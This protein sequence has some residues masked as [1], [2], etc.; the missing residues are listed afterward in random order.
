[1]T[2]YIMEF[3]SEEEMMDYAAT[4]NMEKSYAF[5]NSYGYVGSI[6]KRPQRKTVTRTF[7]SKNTVV[8]T[9]VNGKRMYLGVKNTTFELANAKRMTKTTATTTA[10]SMTAN[11]FYNWEIAFC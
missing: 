6:K 8:F 11:G 4:H 3:V 5:Q 2:E 1:M 7:E 9:Y 10:K